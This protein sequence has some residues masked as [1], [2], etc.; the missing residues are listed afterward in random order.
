MA[1]YTVVETTKLTGDTF[2]FQFN[3]D[4]ENGGLVTMGELVPDSLE[5]YNAVLPVTA[6]LKTEPVYLIT[7]PAWTYDDNKTVDK[8]EENYINPKNKSFK[9]Q[10]PLPVNR[11]KVSDTGINKIDAS[12]ELA[13]GQFVGLANGTSKLKASATVPDDSAFVGEIIDIVNVGFAFSVGQAGNVGYTS[14]KIL[15]QVIKNG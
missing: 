11:F 13:I 5:I 3:A 2:S 9:V 6:T 15:I 1:N 14:K 8:N 7:Q 12:T 4:I 10:K